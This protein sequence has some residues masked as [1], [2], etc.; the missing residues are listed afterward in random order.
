V[1][2]SADA[3][4]LRVFVAEHDRHA[5]QPLY[6]AIADRAL[7][8]GMAGATVLHGS[9]GFGRSR[10]VRTELYVELEQRLPI[11]IEI[12]DSEERI[13]A[14]LPMLDGMMESGLVTFERIK[15]IR[16]GRERAF[17][18]SSGGSDAGPA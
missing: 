8:M 5:R 13:E 1:R 4:L 18:A 17:E 14:F 6:R 2:A 11:V 16:Y 10:L 9:V 15:A 3:I 7:A 12:V